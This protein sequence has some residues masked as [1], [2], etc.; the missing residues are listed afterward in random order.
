LRVAQ[1]RVHAHAQRVRELDEAPGAHPVA[2]LDAADRRRV[3]ARD[4]RE[5]LLTQTEI[6]AGPADAIADSTY[7]RVERF[8]LVSALGEGFTRFPVFMPL[9]VDP[10]ELGDH[11]GVHVCGLSHRPAPPCTPRP[12]LVPR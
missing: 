2:A 9:L 6:L 8:D 5:Q 12:M 3:E 11:P 7:L 10:A 1:Q 4:T